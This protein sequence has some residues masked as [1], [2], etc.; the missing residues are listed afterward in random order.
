MT[1]E[2]VASVPMA[3]DPERA[4]PDLVAASA[5]GDCEAFA[6]LY[7]LVAGRCFGMAVSL[8]RDRARAE[9]VTQEAFLYIWLNSGRYDSRRG[10]ALPWIL[11]IVRARAVDAVRS[12]HASTVRDAAWGLRQWDVEFDPTAERVHASA[13][14]W[15]VRVAMQGLSDKQRSAVGLAFYAGH[16]H[17]EVAGSLGIPV[18]TAKARIRDGLRSLAAALE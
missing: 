16:T 10:Q 17:N 9:E 7:R 15:R 12:S 14:A 1:T 18:G 11:A 13:D 4:L 6:E 5:A 3:V 8:V 2:P